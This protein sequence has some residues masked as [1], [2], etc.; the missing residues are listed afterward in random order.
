MTKWGPR[1][2]LRRLTSF[3]HEIETRYLV[4]H[5]TTATL[6]APRR[7]E[8]L[9][10]A[11]FVVLMHGAVENFVEGLALWVTE[12]VEAGWVQKRRVTRSTASLLF[13]ASCK[14]DDETSTKTVFDTLRGALQGAK[15]ERS[16]AANSNNGIEVKHLRLLLAPLGVDVPDDPML[17]ASLETLVALRHEWAHQYRFG[18]KNP[19]SAKDVKKTCDDCLTLAA[20]LSSRAAALRL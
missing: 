7:A 12:R 6:A 2:E 14:V 10:V 9:D 8:I 5:F 11:A 15:A 17:V 16:N 20:Q 3:V 4:P 18:A 19:K 1:N 13:R